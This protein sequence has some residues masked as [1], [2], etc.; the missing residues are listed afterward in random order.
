MRVLNVAATSDFEREE[1][2]LALHLLTRQVERKLGDK[3][4]AQI[5]VASCTVHTY[6]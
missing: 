6:M 1:L 2:G 5:G 3:L 4:R